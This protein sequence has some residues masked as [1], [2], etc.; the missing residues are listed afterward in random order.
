MRRFLPAGTAALL[1]LLPLV[2]GCGNKVTAPG[3][4]MT[5]QTADDLAIQAA[6]GLVLLGGDIQLSVSSTPQA[7]PAAARR[8]LPA[9]AA[10]DTTVTW[11]GITYQASRTFYDALDNQLSGYGPLAV[12]LRWTSRASGSYAGPRDTA[13]VG[14]DALLDVRGIQGGQDTLRFDGTAHDTLQNT[15]RS[16]DGQR[17]R[18]FFWVSSATV[19]SVRILKS[20]LGTGGW[21]IGGTVTCLV[22]AD[23]LRS[24]SVADVEAHLDATIVVTFD[25]TSQ[26]EILVNG[27]YRYRWN[28]QTGVVSRA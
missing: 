1:L 27:T 26:P 2:A 5:A 12:R 22:S 9:R 3:G 13:S 19:E 15:F 7:P 4:A 25:G 10:W 8:A 24:N 20:T 16:L 11:N 17:V 28:M 6:T 14:R 23:R 18:H 21:P